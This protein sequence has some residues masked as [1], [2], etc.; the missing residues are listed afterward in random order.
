MKKHMS[1]LLALLM[2]ALMVFGLC[3]CGE[4]GVKTLGLYVPE[5]PDDP[6]VVF[7]HMEFEKGNSVR[8]GINSSS[9]QIN[10]LITDYTL[11][12]GQMKLGINLTVD[13]MVIPNVY[14]FEQISD[15]S[16]SLSGIVYVLKN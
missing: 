14:E 8:I 5:N 9:S 13:G 6:N 1:K 7:K 15:T 16:F 2:A 4:K 11:E 10:S 12:E 3:A